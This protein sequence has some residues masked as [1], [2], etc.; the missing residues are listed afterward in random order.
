MKTSDY[1]GTG[2]KLVVISEDHLFQ[3]ILFFYYYVI[4]TQQ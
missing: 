1:Q 2:T 3:V 4:S